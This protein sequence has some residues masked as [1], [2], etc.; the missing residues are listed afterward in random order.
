MVGEG[1]ADVLFRA[2]EHGFQNAGMGGADGFVLLGLEAE[3]PQPLDV[4]EGGEHMVEVILH[5]AEGKGHAVEGVVE[6]QHPGLP[7]L[8]GGLVFQLAVQ[9]NELAVGGLLLGGDVAADAVEHLFFQRVAGKLLH[10]HQ[11]EVDGGHMGAALGLDGDHV[12]D[13]EH[14]EGFPHGGAADAQLLRQFPVVELVA[15]LEFHGDDPAADGLIGHLAC[16]PC[17]HCPSPPFGSSRVIYQFHCTRAGRRRQEGPATKNGVS[18][19]SFRR[20]RAPTPPP[21]P[22]RRPRPRWSAVW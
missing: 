5:A 3:L 20:G 17:G 11:L 2:V 9:L 7:A 15:G 8:G 16:T 19:F 21:A 4:L 18:A 22:A 13:V 10:L 12:G 1:A 14:D 6:V